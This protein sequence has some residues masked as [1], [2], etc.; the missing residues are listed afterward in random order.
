MPGFVFNLTEK[1]NVLIYITNNHIY[2]KL[3]YL[4]KNNILARNCKVT[5]Y[6]LAGQFYFK[7]LLIKRF[8]GTIPPFLL[9][10]GHK[11]S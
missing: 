4:C 3:F 5:C 10:K 6:K 11:N 8:I 1:I 2:N 7:F 9:Q